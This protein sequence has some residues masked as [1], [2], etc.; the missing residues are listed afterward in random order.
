MSFFNPRKVEK[1][2]DFFS[3]FS[4]YTPGVGGMFTVLLWFLAGMFLGMLVVIPAQFGFADIPNSYLFPIVYVVQFVPVLIFTKYMSSRN[5]MFDVGYALDSKHFGKA[6][7]GWMA[8]LAVI[9]TLSAALMLE[10]VNSF[11]PEMSE[12]WKN[13]MKMLMDAP[14]WITLLSTCVL[15]PIFEEWM[16]RGIVLR[17]L[18]HAKRKD[19]EG[20][21][22]A[23]I[24]PALAIVISA[25]FFATIHG[26]LWQGITAFLLGCLLGYVYYRTGSLKLTILMHF[27]NNFLSAM[28]SY[29]GGEKVENAKSLLDLIPAWQY[30]ILFALSAVALVL[31]LRYMKSI[32]LQSPAGN[33]DPIDLTT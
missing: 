26:N 21:V 3:G 33:S 9:A 8:L 24:S 29:F 31:I 6:G 20:N 7:G 19:K 15:A 28:L 1:N 11:L 4:W 27:A 32:P 10:L 22:K 30:S 14:L 23:G 12:T 17:G 18:L 5:A 13:A 2:Y 16:C 25:L